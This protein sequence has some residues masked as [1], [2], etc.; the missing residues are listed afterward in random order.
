MSES[1]DWVEFGVTRD[2]HKKEKVA[3]KKNSVRK[4]SPELT[5]IHAAFE[6]HIEEDYRAGDMFN[7]YTLDRNE[8]G[9]Y[10]N[11]SVKMQ[12]PDF[13]AGWIAA[14]KFFKKGAQ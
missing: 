3:R 9:S 2:I 4:E 5:A 6:K 14:K 1:Q 11:L 10:T 13:K 8:Y 7:D 12:Y